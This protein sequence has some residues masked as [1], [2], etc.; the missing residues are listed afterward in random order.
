[1]GPRSAKIC[2]RVSKLCFRNLVPLILPAI[3]HI[4]CT[5]GGHKALNTLLWR[6]ANVHKAGGFG[7]P[8][9]LNNACFCCVLSNTRA[10]YADNFVI[11]L[12]VLFHQCAQVGGWQR[13]HA[14]A[15]SLL[16]LPSAYF[17]ILADCIITIHC[18]T[19]ANT[20]GLE[21]HET[22]M[23]TLDCLAQIFVG[24][25]VQLVCLR[26]CYNEIWTM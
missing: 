10:S 24:S 21:S 8:S 12:H 9:V 5:S 6:Y 13:H 23:S 25:A 15:L 2:L 16:H 19:S 3:C 14:C 17:G 7:A 11:A 1:M 26:Q 22:N 4:N 18:N 20:Q